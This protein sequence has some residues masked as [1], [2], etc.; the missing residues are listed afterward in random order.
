[1]PPI[2]TGLKSFLSAVGVNMVPVPWGYQSGSA[3]ATVSDAHTTD[4]ATKFLKAGIRSVF[5]D[6]S[7]EINPCRN[8]RT[9]TSP[10][11]VL[12]LQGKEKPAGRDLNERPLA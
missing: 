11:Q 5:L 3:A 8:N 9:K 6:G 4:L 10:L 1:M 2:C 7:A 12:G